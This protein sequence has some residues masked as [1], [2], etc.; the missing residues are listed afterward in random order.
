MQAMFPFLIESATDGLV[1]RS[2][3]DRYSIPQTTIL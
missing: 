1:Q 3:T 2:K